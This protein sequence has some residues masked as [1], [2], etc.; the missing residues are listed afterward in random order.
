VPKPTDRSYRVFVGFDEGPPKA[1][2]K[3]GS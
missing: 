3:A 1:A 2:K